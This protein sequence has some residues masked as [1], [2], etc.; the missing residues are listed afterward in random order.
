MTRLNEQLTFTS[1]QTLNNRFMLAPLTN[2]QSEDNGVLGE[3]EYG[4][5]TRRAEG[6]F[7]LTM[8]CATSVQFEGVGFPGQLGAYAPRHDDGLARLA[9]GLKAHSTHA[10]VQLHHGGMRAI[11]DYIGRAPMCPSDDAE[12]GS[13][14]M[15]AAEIDRTIEDFISA[16]QRCQ[17]AGFDG[18]QIHGAHG[19]LVGQFLSPKYNQRD[20]AYGG[21]QQNRERLLFEIIEG[22][23]QACGRNFSL[24]VRL[25]PERF[26]IDTA[27]SIDLASRLLSDE[28]LDYV[29]MSLWAVNKPCPHP[30]Y[31]DQ[32]MLDVFS[33]LPRN[34]VK[35]IA[36]GNLRTAA[37]CQAAID[38]GLDMVAIG[39]AAI[40]HHDFPRQVVAD[41]GFVPVPLPVSPQHLRQEAV[42]DAFLNYLSTQ[43]NDFVAA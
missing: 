38:A 4:W 31:S 10:V 36:S 7:G 39:R 34:G 13:V 35:L 37:D 30:D 2:L 33:N 11:A 15:T 20:D 16:A 14:A 23:N 8:T 18:V 19:Y 6:G 25:S 12:T 24:G 27:E 26:G 32:S 17:R 41:G 40:L 3:D 43:W 22:I 21:S 28:R 29:D 5:L 42:G 1:G 9:A